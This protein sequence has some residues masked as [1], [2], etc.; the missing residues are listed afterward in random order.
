MSGTE[1]EAVEAGALEPV[2]VAV[3]DVI[4]QH[5][6][7][8]TDDY[9]KA[10][11]NAR[12]WRAVEAALAVHR[13][14]VAREVIAANDAEWCA[15]IEAATVRPEGQPFDTAVM[16]A[17]REA[18]RRDERVRIHAALEDKFDNIDFDHWWA[19]SHR[20]ECIVDEVCGGDRAQG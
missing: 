5:P 8:S 4:A 11:E 9:G 3:R 10:A 2:Y 19:I 13:E 17:I 15:N 18:A 1:N 14:I 6:P 20:V 12:I 16:E 7:R